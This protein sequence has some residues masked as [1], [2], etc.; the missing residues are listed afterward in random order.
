[1]AADHK[2][3]LSEAQ[4]TIPFTIEV[5]PTQAV[6][7]SGPDIAAAAQNQEHSERGGPEQQQ[8]CVA[9]QHRA[10]SC[11]AWPKTV[12]PWCHSSTDLSEYILAFNSPCRCMQRVDIAVVAP[13]ISTHSEA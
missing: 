9:C 12:C 4:T 1:M 6:V 3:S 7:T 8:V 13:P 5:S 2:C 11:N 10:H